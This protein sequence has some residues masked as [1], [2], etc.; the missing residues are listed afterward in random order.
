[1]LCNPLGVCSPSLAQSRPQC[2]LCPSV[3]WQC[4]PCPLLTAP[5]AG[6]GLGRA[7]AGTEQQHCHQGRQQDKVPLEPGCPSLQSWGGKSPS[8]WLLLHC[9]QADRRT[10]PGPH[11]DTSPTPVCWPAAAPYSLHSLSSWGRCHRAWG[12]ILSSQ[13]ASSRER[14]TVKP[15]CPQYLPWQDVERMAQVAWGRHRLAPS[16]CVVWC[17]ALAPLL[18]T[19]K[20]TAAVLLI[21][22]CALA[23]SPCEVSFEP[24]TT[25]SEVYLSRKLTHHDSTAAQG[26]NPGTQQEPPCHAQLSM[27]PL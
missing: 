6:A 14:T 5:G 17:F 3:P 10:F 22:L 19:G 16:L 26:R 11:R 8:P 25:Q 24:S 20:L 21:I 7:S 27:L 15:R 18:L 23:Y 1:M 13:H 4:P 2:P 12:R 9:S